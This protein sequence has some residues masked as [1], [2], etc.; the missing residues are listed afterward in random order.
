M[1]NESITYIFLFVAMYFEI[2]LLM[3][4][5][6]IRE[7]EKSV[8]IFGEPYALQA[9]VS[10]MNAFSDHA[11]QGE[12]LDFIVRCGKTLKQIFIVHGEKT[13]ALALQEVLREHGISQTL[14]PSRGQKVKL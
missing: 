12:L 5:F 14:V 8:K 13:Q 6:E 4:Y 7:K 10:V 3:T 9:E 1:V 11:D 2:F